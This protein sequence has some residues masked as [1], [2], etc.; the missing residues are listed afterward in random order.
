MSTSNE[1]APSEKDALSL[2]QEVDW[3]KPLVSPAVLRMGRQGID[4]TG[5]RERPLMKLRGRS[6]SEEDVEVGVE[7]WGHGKIN[8]HDPPN[9]IQ[10]RG[11]STNATSKLSPCRGHGIGWGLVS[12]PESSSSSVEI[13]PRCTDGKVDGIQANGVRTR[14][15]LYKFN[16]QASHSEKNRNSN[17][18]DHRL[19]EV[20]ILQRQSLSTLK[21]LTIL[22]PLTRIEFDN[23][24]QL[25]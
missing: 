16:T 10:I 2:L 5:M 9:N 15:G 23:R 19:N 21:I 11:S 14:Q 17:S 6:L 22:D 1:I 3:L 18:R 13:S 20:G 8:C 7:E 25:S 12:S 24:R 4:E